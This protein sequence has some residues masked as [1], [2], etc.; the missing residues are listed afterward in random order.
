MEELFLKAYLWI[1]GVTPPDEYYN[2]LHEIFMRPENENNQILLELEDCTNSKTDTFHTFHMVF[3]NTDIWNE[4]HFL[5]LFLEYLQQQ[6]KENSS[7]NKTV[8]LGGWLSRELPLSDK[9]RLKQPISTLD[10]LAEF[11]D[12]GFM[13]LYSIYDQF[14][15]CIYFY[16]N[17]T[18]KKAAFKAALQ[19]DNI[20]TQKSTLEKKIITSNEAEQTKKTSLFSRLFKKKSL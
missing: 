18:E 14:F 16:S 13:S 10:Y 19:R 5:K 1:N 8:E 3:Y 17:V 7:V 20:H 9:T 2:M 12:D 4:E 11:I 6:Y 15:D